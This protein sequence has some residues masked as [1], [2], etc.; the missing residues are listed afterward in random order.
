MK[1]LYLE[2][3]EVYKC[4]NNYSITN[5]FRRD[6]MN[7][8]QMQT[9]YRQIV[10]PEVGVSGQEKLLSSSVLICGV[11]GLGSP[12]AFYLTAMGVGRIGLIDGDI[13]SRTN[14]NR[15]ILYTP[16][17]IGSPKV[18]VAANRLRLQN[19]D[20]NIETYFML[21]SKEN[22]TDII[23]K[24]DIIVDCF[25]NFEARFILN[26]ACIALGKPFVHAGVHSLY[27]QTITVIPGKSPCLRCI[28]PDG[29]KAPKGEASKGILGAT[30][31][32][33]GA[34]EAMEVFK[35]LLGMPVNNKDLFI[36]N[37]MEADCQ[38][39]N[40]KPNPDCLCQK[41]C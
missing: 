41:R 23:N 33:M 18:E 5:I 8:I 12:A 37:G 22:A 10:L 27:G 34:F 13:V 40:I 11:G 14:L 31:G 7:E 39:V 29:Y 19:P 30:A 32:V 36:F 38:S 9:Y 3:Q 24:Y 4:Y 15:Q 20:V 16:N 21:L 1:F 28:L 35:Y 17:D 2:T 6:I 25:D 26:D